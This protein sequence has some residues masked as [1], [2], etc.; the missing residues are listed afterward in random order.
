MARGK[1]AAPR[2]RAAAKK[3]PAKAT[4]AAKKAPAKKKARKQVHPVYPELKSPAERASVVP[5]APPTVYTDE[6]F[7]AVLDAMVDPPTSLRKVCARP[8]MPNRSTFFYWLQ[9]YPQ[10]RP[11]YEA[12]VE[13][14]AD[15]FID[16]V[17]DI[18]DDAANDW[19]EVEDRNGKTR[20]VLDKEHVM[21]SRL[22][23]EA[24]FRMAEMT[25][26]QKYGRV[27]R[28]TG[29]KG[30][31]VEH[32]HDVASILDEIDGADTGMGPAQPAPD[33]G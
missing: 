31:P 32:T 5:K 14:R 13:A 23:V 10:L 6:L 27:M 17:N 19:M 2:K 4:K 20:M 29:P 28:H 8:G 11:K 26:P 24:R 16:E 18:A 9:Q 25:A 1:A 33:H 22:R 3:P 7:Q 15:A 30:G 21:R 12:A